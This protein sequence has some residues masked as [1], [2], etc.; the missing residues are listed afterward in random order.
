MRRALPL[1]LVAF[2]AAACGDAPSSDSS[3]TDAP[4]DTMMDM[5]V[6]DVAP[7]ATYVKP[8]VS[9]PA[10]TPTELEVTPL[11]SG[12]GPAAQAGDGIV[13]RY[14]GVRSE[15]GTEFDSNY[16]GEP[17]AF[18]LGEGRVIQGWDQGLVGAQQGERV[19]LD[20]PP[21]LAYGDSP[22]GDVIQAGD[23]LTFVVDVVAVLPAFTADAAPEVE[24]AP[25]PNSGQVRSTDLVVGEG[26]ELAEGATGIIHIVV[27]RADTGERLDATWGTSPLTFTNSAETQ[28]YSGILQAV[29]GMR[30][31]GRRQAQIPYPLMFN[32]QGNDTLGLPPETDVVLVIDLIG[33]Y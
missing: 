2:L 31:G 7:G 22:Q 32:G 24:V 8:T 18:T 30:V 10:T 6:S 17:F 20:I 21:D 11:Q 9:I 28:V 4:T 3:G 5:S 26:A 16:D 27:Y 14:V 13:V 25:A 19:Q 1:V 33:Q 29:D 12:S 15:D 23:A